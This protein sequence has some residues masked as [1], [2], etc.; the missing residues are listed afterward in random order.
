MGKAYYRHVIP[1]N[2][3]HLLVA[4]NLERIAERG[5]KKGTGTDCLLVLTRGRGS[6]GTN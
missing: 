3:S 4:K 1:C 5:E 6:R 2:C